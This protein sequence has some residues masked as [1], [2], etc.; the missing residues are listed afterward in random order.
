LG[1][2]VKRILFFQHIFST[3][4]SA[5]ENGKNITSRMARAV[6]TPTDEDRAFTH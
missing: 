6:K 1:K 3:K 5:G 2:Y 4:S